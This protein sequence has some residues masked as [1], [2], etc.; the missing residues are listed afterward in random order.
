MRVFQGQRRA[1]FTVSQLNKLLE[2]SMPHLW[3]IV[4]HAVKA[5]FDLNKL[6]LAVNSTA[7]NPAEETSDNFWYIS[8]SLYWVLILNAQ[9]LRRFCQV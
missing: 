8:G 6:C 2:Q 4:P 5:F 3:V 9:Q 1:R 7:P